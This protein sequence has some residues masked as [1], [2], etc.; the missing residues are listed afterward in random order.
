MSQKRTVPRA[1]HLDAREPGAP[2][3][4]VVG[5]ARLGGP[6][7]LL[8]PLHQREVAAVAAE[9]RHARV[10]VPVHEAGHE[11]VAAGVDDVVVRARR[12]DVGA[13]RGDDPVDRRA[14]RP[15]RRRATSRW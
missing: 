2:V 4:V 11:H 9:Q 15:V 1:D 13:Q 7:L 5:E 3:D 10:G 8:E 14:A 6:D 12:V